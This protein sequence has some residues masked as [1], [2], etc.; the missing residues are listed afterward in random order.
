M[1][2]L[3]MLLRDLFDVSASSVEARRQLVG[4]SKP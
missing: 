1:K 4:K 3:W 2:R